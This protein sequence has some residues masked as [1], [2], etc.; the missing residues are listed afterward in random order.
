MMKKIDTRFGGLFAVMLGVMGSI[1]AQ[2]QTTG[3]NEGASVEPGAQTQEEL[4]QQAE[5][6]E[7]ALDVLLRDQA[8]LFR[9]GELEFEVGALYASD[10]RS[11]VRVR[12]GFIPAVESRT[13]G[14]TFT[15]R[16]GIT[17]RL[18]FNI[19]APYPVYTER[20]LVGFPNSARDDDLGLGDASAGLSY[21]L[22]VERG[23]RPAVAL[24]LDAKS[25]TGKGLLGSGDW[26]VSGGSTLVKT[27]DPVVFF[28]GL[29]YTKT[30]EQNG[31]DN[32][33]E[34]SYLSG[35]A[36]SLND[37]VSISAQVNGATVKAT[38]INSEEVDD[39]SLDILSLQLGTTALV[40]N[41]LFIEPLVNI[42][43]TDDASDAAVGL[44]FVYQFRQLFPIPFL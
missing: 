16:Y 44:N 29:G 8:V 11:D 34:I 30:F 2:A 28:G 24:N 12:G 43:L 3:E 6:A 36:F 22:L 9:Q 37:R 33:D 31:I 21:Q 5:E 14:L 40:G 39:S 13:A 26:S 4:R 23:A 32:G 19:T 35:I 27:I 15:G 17:S 38:E 10:R 7:R 41:S 25:D 20:K 42:G 1:S 18:L